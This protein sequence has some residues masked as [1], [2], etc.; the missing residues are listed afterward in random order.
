MSTRHLQTLVSRSS[1]RLTNPLTPLTLNRT[2]T[3]LTKSLVRNM[4]SGID[5][6]NKDVKTATGVTLSE[7]Q[8]TLV[9]SILD[10]RPP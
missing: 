10:V 3:D 2:S 4:T 9:G 7:K 1:T 5:I 8:E 6:E